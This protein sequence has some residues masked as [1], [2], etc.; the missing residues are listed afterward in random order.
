LKLYAITIQPTSGFGTPLKGDT[1]FGHFCWQVAYDSGLLNGGLD[2]WITVYGERPFV[3]FSSA[4]PT[5]ERESVQYAFKRPDLPISCLFPLPEL[6]NKKDQLLEW[7]KCKGRKWMI[8]QESLELALASAKYITDDEL[9]ES[10]DS[11]ISNG[12]ASHSADKPTGYVCTFDQPHNTINRIS[13]STGKGMFAPFSETASY[14][15]PG[16][17]LTIFVF[18]DGDATDIERVYTAMERIGKWGF[19][20]DASTGHGRFSMQGFKEISIPRTDSANACYVLGPTV[21]QKGLF[22]ESFFTPFVRFGKHGDRLVRSGNPFKNPVVMAD[23]GAVFMTD[24]PEVFS[25]PYIGK[26]VT[27]LSKSMPR[28]VTQGYSIYLPFKM[29][30]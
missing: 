8:V 1:I 23:E 12:A 26:G 22:S 30:M 18:V 27:S 29:E 19:G 11:T 6:G 15:C 10:E 17:K 13:G 14:Y 2:N 25:K 3:V 9:F 5:I 21:P 20:K 24:N 28:S 16:A 7:K 4:W